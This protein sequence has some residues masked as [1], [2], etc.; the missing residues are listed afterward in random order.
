MAI[1]PALQKTVTW[2]ADITAPVLTISGPANLG[3]NPDPEDIDAALGVASAFDG[4]GSPTLLT[5]TGSVVVNGCN[6]S[7]T[8]TFTSTDACG[9]FA[10]ASRTV[11]W[12]VDAGPPAFSGNF[13]TVNLGCNPSPTTI[14]AVLGGATASDGCGAPTLVSIDGAIVSNGC[15]RSRTRMF[16]AL[17]ACGSTASVS[18]TVNWVADITPP[19]FIGDYSP[20]TL[21]ANPEPG[22]IS[23][24]LGVATASDACGTLFIAFSDGPV[25]SNGCD[26]SQTRTFT[27][28]DACG[29]FATISRTVTWNCGLTRVNPI[30]TKKHPKLP[31][32]DVKAYPNPTEHQFT[33]YIEGASTEKV[34][35][36]IFDALGRLVKKIE[37]GDPMNA[38]RFGEDLKTGVYM[39]EVRQGVNRKTLKLIKQ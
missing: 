34:Q 21:G 4:C 31:S 2:F 32:F 27:A 13:T 19:A 8:R 20:V 39:V 23:S 6:R 11:T 12:I 38:I 30:Y 33:L 22:E 29:N 17:D 35:V 1:H 28:T 5:N 10:S 9:N 7:Q 37:R 26:R 15:N 3:C 25:I 16:I 14:N 24:A 18:R 36:V